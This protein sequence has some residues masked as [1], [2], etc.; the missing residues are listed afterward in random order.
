M[1]AF[2]F[3]KN[4][5]SFLLALSVVFLRHSFVRP[6]RSTEWYSEKDAP[7]EVSGESVIYDD[8]KKTYL[9][10]GD[11]VITQLDMTLTARKPRST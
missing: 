5:L 10:E 7:I 2:L 8:A 1:G 6:W 9:A 3:N 11:V 4:N